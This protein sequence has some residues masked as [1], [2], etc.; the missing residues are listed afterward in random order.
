M[1][2]EPF[3]RLSTAPFDRLRA[4]GRLMAGWLALAL[5]CSALSRRADERLSPL[6]PDW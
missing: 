5:R 3:D 1:W 6:P 2:A 4:Y